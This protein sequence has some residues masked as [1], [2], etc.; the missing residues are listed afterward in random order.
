MRYEPTRPPTPIDAPTG[1]MHDQIED[2]TSD[3]FDGIVALNGVVKAVV[4]DLPTAD[5]DAVED[6]LGVGLEEADGIE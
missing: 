4:G 2:V 3:G 1:E 6:Y 5:K